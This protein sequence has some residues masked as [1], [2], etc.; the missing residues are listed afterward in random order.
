MSRYDDDRRDDRDDRRGGG[1]G[2][3]GGQIADGCRIYVGNLPNDVREKEVDDLFYKYGRIRDISI[4][5]GR[6]GPA[7]AFL[8]FSDPRDADDAIYG[9]D[10]YRFGGRGLRVERPRGANS[11][12]GAGDR[13]GRGGGS[14]GGK[15]QFKVLVEGIPDGGSWQDLKDNC[16]D[17]GINAAHTSV[18]G[19][20]GGTIELN[21][22]E[23]IARAIDKLDDTKFK[24]TRTSED[25]YIR[26]KRDPDGPAAAGGG[27]AA[28]R[29]RSPERRSRSRSKSRSKS[30]ARKSSRSPA[31]KS[32]SPARSRSR[33]PPARKSRSRSRSPA[34]D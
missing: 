3:R 8:E 1:G 14:A 24:S 20:G 21:S 6:G 4:K 15:S 2:Y 22:E 7:F 31:R 33:S 34:R 25:V 12:G 18:D 16:R 29:S 5:G 13:G 26:V 9:R 27:D 17:A 30:P 19:K 28:K 10:R 32:R 11:G 23:D